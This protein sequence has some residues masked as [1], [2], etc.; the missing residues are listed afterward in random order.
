MIQNKVVADLLQHRAEVIRGCEAFQKNVQ[1]AVPM[2]GLALQALQCLLCSPAVLFPGDGD[3]AGDFQLSRGVL[4]KVLTPSGTAF[5]V[6]FTEVS[7]VYQ[8]QDCVYVT[9]LQQVHGPAP[10]INTLTITPFCKPA[11]DTWG[12]GP[13]V[14]L[15]AFL[16]ESG[17]S[18]V[19]WFLTH[20]PI[21]IGGSFHMAPLMRCIDAVRD[22]TLFFLSKANTQHE[23][24]VRFPIADKPGTSLQV[25]SKN[26]ALWEYHEVKLSD[27]PGY[28]SQPKGGTHASPRWHM[29]RGHWRKYKTGKRVW[30]D[31]MEVGDKALG[32]VAHDY[33]VTC[34]Q[35]EV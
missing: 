22:V 11:G 3:D 29:R 1:L 2:Q 8:I 4:T 20:Q 24:M 31:N 33:V 27:V 21:S 19:E 14:T 28:I 17:E 5:A 30:I 12:V 32:V 6:P 16:M 25:A 10:G 15:A 26:K 35:M 13:P 9:L 18:V 7:L 34:N 23:G